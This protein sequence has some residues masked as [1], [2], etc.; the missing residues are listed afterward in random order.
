MIIYC[1]YH[2]VGFYPPPKKIILYHLNEEIGVQPQTIQ[3]DETFQSVIF[4]VFN[5]SNM[6]Q[7]YNK[8]R[9]VG[10]YSKKYYSK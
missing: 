4:F 3:T 10:F 1:L 6:N 2:Y 7:R 9:D 5:Y 8:L